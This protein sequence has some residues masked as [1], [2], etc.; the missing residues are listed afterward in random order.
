MFALT[1]STAVDKRSERVLLVVWAASVAEIEA[2][3]MLVR[4]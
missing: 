1:A 4:R 2:G 3:E